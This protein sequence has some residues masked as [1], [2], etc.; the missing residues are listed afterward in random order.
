MM[1]FANAFLNSPEIGRH[2]E[3]AGCAIHYHEQGE[4]PLLILLHGLGFSI[5]TYRFIISDLSVHYRVISV[6]LPGCGYSRGLPGK[7]SVD[8]VVGALCEFIASVSG[9]EPAVLLGT[10]EGAVYAMGLC[11][12][13][14]E[15][16]L[17]MVLESP[18]GLTR[19][20]PWQWQHLLTPIVGEWLMRRM[21]EKEMAHLLDWQLFNRT[22]VGECEVHQLYQPFSA[23][24]TRRNLLA[25]LRRFDDRGVLR[26]ISGIRCPVCLIWGANDS[27]HPAAMSAIYTRGIPGCQYRAFRNCG[28]LVHEER[29]AEF[30]ETVHGFLSLNMPRKS[31]D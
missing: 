9:G 7:G 28:H 13:H 12:R 23:L 30:C 24:E 14:P 31:L 20:Y 4:G 19:Y 18:G 27:C 11:E 8:A 2:L 17:A 10:A 15:S 29:P 22:R 21:S 26:R 5:Y 1:P 16:V 6:D 25:L 3:V